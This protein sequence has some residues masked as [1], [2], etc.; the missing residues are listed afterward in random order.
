MRIF[1][2]LNKLDGYKEVNLSLDKVLDKVR[3]SSEK[4]KGIVTFDTEVNC[5]GDSKCE[6]ALLHKFQIC[7]DGVYTLLGNTTNEFIDVINLIYD[8]L[9]A[10]E[11]KGKTYHSLIIFGHNIAYDYYI[12]KPV[13]DK[14]DWIV[15]KEIGSSTNVK[16]VTFE[17]GVTLKC[18]YKYSEQSLMKVTEGCL[19]PKH[20]GD[21][22]FT[23]FHHPDNVLKSEEL[24]YC[25]NDVT[26]LYEYIKKE[27]EL[28]QYKDVY[29]FPMTKT[30]R[31]RFDFN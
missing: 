25:L 4:Y 26:G 27:M 15:D 5:F 20:K 8:K 12:L 18:T 3:T 16:G 24:I 9:S 28:C 17:N 10:Y 19:H 11:E 6:F 31:V 21:L 13:F 29:E 23:K 30:S 7:L 2:V 1:K 22:E 14:A